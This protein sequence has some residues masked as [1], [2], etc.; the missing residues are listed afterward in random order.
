MGNDREGRRALSTEY[1]LR[2]KRLGFRRWRDEDFELA[3]GLWGDPKVT[4]LID[5]RG[6]LTPAHVRERLDQEI[7]HELFYRVQ[8][9]PVFR[10][11]DHA[12]VGCC[13]LR[14]RSPAQRVYEIGFHI[15][16]S[17]WRQGYALEAARAVVTHA[18]YA[19][20][21]SALFAGHTP[22]NDASRRLL[23]KLGFEYQRDEFYPPTGLNHPS[24]L[25]RAK[26]E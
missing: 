8:Y 4:E 24:Y 19:L 18:F 9:W 15:R 20:G 10:L 11:D 25:L 3:L 23:E 2:T 21:A 6:T 7:A 5:A 26:E 1:F 17:H 22:R 16:S 13:G 12:H 14:P